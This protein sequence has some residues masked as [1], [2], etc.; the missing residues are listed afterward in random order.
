MS[1]VTGTVVR[2][3]KDKS[4]TVVISLTGKLDKP[5]QWE[6]LRVCLEACLKRFKLKVEYK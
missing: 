6:E 4:K 3:G 2:T 1:D 5:E